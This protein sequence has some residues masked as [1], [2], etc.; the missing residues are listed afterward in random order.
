MPITEGLQELGEWSLS[1]RPETPAR[2]REAV[3]H[4]Q[5]TIVVTSGPANPDVVGDDGVLA[6]ARY[7]GVLLNRTDLEIGG[8]GMAWWLGDRDDQGTIYNGQFVAD[9]YSSAYTELVTTFG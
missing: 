3:W 9:T 5:S 8:A 4:A 2:V 7:T 6:L 1:L